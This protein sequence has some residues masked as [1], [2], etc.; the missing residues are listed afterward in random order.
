M[1]NQNQKLNDEIHLVYVGTYTGGG[2]EGIYICHLDLSNG[3][4]RQIGVARNVDNPSYLAIDAERNRLFAVNELSEFNGLLGGGVSAFA[5]E[6]ASGE[7]TFIN[8]QPSQGG[9]PCYI[10]LD[11]TGRNLLVANLS[12]IR[13][14][15]CTRNG[16][17]DHTP[18]RSFSIQPMRML[19]CLT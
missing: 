9:A 19:L 3:E 14:A 7:L 17:K 12:S 11:R 6:P 18:I 8:Q 16:K 10:S 1:N 15:G 13:E 2:S 4:L 5:I